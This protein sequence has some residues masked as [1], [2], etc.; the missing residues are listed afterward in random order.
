MVYR[1]TSSDAS[2]AKHYTL[3]GITVCDEWK[4]SFEAFLKDV[5][6]KPS[7]KHTLDRIDNNQGYTPG[8]VRW[9]TRIEQARNQRRTTMLTYQDETRPL[10]E[11]AEIVGI[12]QRT[13]KSRLKMGWSTE[14]A[15]TTPSKPIGRG[16]VRLRQNTD[17]SRK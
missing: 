15:L 6:P 3:R 11:W 5:G 17:Y 10:T 16:L 1:G 2:F 4:N 7:Q 14:A 13:I 12:P 9:A 8:N